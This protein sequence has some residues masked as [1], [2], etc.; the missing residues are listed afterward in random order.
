[1]N[2]N[3]PPGPLVGGTT[4]PHTS[5]YGTIGT[6]GEP[7][8]GKQL[9]HGPQYGNNI[10]HNVSEWVKFNWAVYRKRRKDFQGVFSA[11]KSKEA[12]RFAWMTATG[13]FC[14]NWFFQ[15]WREN[16]RWAFNYSKATDVT[17][18]DIYTHNQAV[19]CRPLGGRL[20]HEVVKDHLESQGKSAEQLLYGPTTKA[21]SSPSTTD[22]HKMFSSTLKHP[23]NF[24]GGGRGGIL[25]I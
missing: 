22:S 6:R 14:M 3:A 4:E 20:D 11:P 18:M 8:T 17:P 21:V 7:P 16:E 5:H 19:L 10:Y 12:K 25:N 1:M 24:R 23:K 15:N 2:G 13:L 9:S